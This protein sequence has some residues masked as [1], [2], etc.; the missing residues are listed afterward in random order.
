MKSLKVIVVC[1]IVA[2]LSSTVSFAS[3]LNI[4]SNSDQQ[5]I[6]SVQYNKNSKQFKNPIKVLESK[7]EQIQSELKS[8]QIAE[9]KAN[10]IISKINSK[11]KKIQEFNSLSV[12]Q[13]KERLISKFEKRINE[14]VHQ[15]QISKDKADELIKK[16][17]HKINSWNGNGY[18]H[19]KNH[20]FPGNFKRQ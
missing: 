20:Y 7:K 15:K 3:P 4:L 1:A 5:L 14:K 11:I 8:G 12:Q 9:D 13:K 10:K 2:S 17:T 19:F 18:P 16:Y 6:N